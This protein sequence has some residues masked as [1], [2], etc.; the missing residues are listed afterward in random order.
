MRSGYFLLSLISIQAWT[1]P[2]DLNWSVEWFSIYQITADRASQYFLPPGRGIEPL[3]C[4]N[5]RGRGI[6]PPWSVQMSVQMSVH[7]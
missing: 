1:L 2:F 3:H 5:K 7:T 4:L 6:I